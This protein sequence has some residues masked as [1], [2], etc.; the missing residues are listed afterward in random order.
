[1]DKA[2]YPPT[3]RHDG[4][5][6][7][8]NHTCFP[9]GPKSSH[10]QSFI[11]PGFIVRTEPGTRK[12][13]IRQQLRTTSVPYPHPHT[14]FCCPAV[15]HDPPGAAE[16]IPSPPTHKHE[17]KATVTATVRT[18]APN[19]SRHQHR[20]PHPAPAAHGSSETTANRSVRAVAPDQARCRYQLPRLPCAVIPVPTCPPPPS[21]ATSPPQ[22][23]TQE[24]EEK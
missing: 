15:T 10:F 18:V 3:R 21:H 11:Q 5:L 23:K 19:K 17:G 4:A 12:C 1:M 22:W 6:V 9:A 16:F 24:E 8:P 13:R 20:P 7:P 2:N 14:L